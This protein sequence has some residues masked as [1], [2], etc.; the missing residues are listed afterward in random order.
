MASIHG[1][2]GRRCRYTSVMRLTDRILE[3]LR[4][5]YD[6]DAWHGTPLRRLLD[7]VD[8]DSV[9]SRP[10]TNTRSIAELLA[11]VVAWIQIVDRRLHGE[12]F[13]ITPEMDFPEGDAMPWGDLVASLE[14]SHERLLATV[15]ALD[16]QTLEALVPG[17]PYTRW[18]MLNGL[19]HHNTYHAA[20]IALLK[21]G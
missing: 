20:Q 11:H 17:K 6:G 21:K 18:F 13:E 15:A 4:S 12:V 10:I 19:V 16:D 3:T 9:H 2:T 8:P 1:S 7:D 5:T 14:Q